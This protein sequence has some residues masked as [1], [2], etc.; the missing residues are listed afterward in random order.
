MAGMD[1]YTNEDEISAGVAVVLE[2]EGHA[3]VEG[4]VSANVI[5]LFISI[6][7]EEDQLSYSE[8]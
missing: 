2:E 7:W 1:L 6:N 3:D 5:G 8:G 4:V